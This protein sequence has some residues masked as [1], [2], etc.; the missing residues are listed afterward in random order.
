[1]Y[2]VIVATTLREL[3]L[4]VSEY[5]ENGFLL[6]GGVTTQPYYDSVINHTAK[7]SYTPGSSS[8][9]TIHYLQAVYNPQPKDLS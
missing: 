9:Y 5:L 3:E 8:S 4:R 2:L 6:S 1:M 7:R